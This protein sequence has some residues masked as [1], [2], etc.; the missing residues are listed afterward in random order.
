[1][2]KTF[3]CLPSQLDEEGP[4]LIRYLEIMRLGT[5]EQKEEEEGE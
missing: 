2:C 4:E 3:G 5:P 1:M